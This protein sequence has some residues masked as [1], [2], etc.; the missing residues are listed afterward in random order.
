MTKQTT[1][2]VSGALRVKGRSLHMCMAR[3]SENSGDE[4][5]TFYTVALFQILKLLFHAYKMHT[6]TI[7]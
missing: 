3:N 1:I 6:L 5:N 2:V 7:K 4:P